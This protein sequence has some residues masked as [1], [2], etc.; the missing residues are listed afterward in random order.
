MNWYSLAAG[1]DAE[2]DTFASVAGI[3]RNQ[4]CD[5][6]DLLS[7][8][9]R[10]DRLPEKTGPEEYR[11]WLLSNAGSLSRLTGANG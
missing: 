4:A 11:S 10:Q 3:P 8:N 5:R 6:S 9:E 2:F 7:D 1:F